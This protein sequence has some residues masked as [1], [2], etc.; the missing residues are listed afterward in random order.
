MSRTTALIATALL[1]GASGAPAMAT[2]QT[3]PPQTAAV[4]PR[5]RQPATADVRAAY[6]RADPLAR[7]IFWTEQAEINP[8]DPIAGVK[9]AVA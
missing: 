5:T 1:L 8:M 3:A 9:A 7:Q 4:A 6:D 2:V